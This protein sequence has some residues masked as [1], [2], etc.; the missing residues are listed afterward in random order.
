M[1]PCE[2][3][4]GL[5]TDTHY[6]SIASAVGGVARARPPRDPKSGPR[7]LPARHRVHPT[8]SGDDQMARRLR[9]R[10]ASRW[11]FPMG[12]RIPSAHG[13]PS[14]WGNP[15]PWHTGVV[16]HA[17]ALCRCTGCVSVKL[18]LFR[19]QNAISPCIPNCDAL[20]GG[21]RVLRHC[22]RNRLWES[23]AASSNNI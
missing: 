21:N 18:R 2:A 8:T 10:V 17:P 11:A 14:E 22:G 15:L 12:V 4:F 7:E 6:P 9:H 1:C 20:S 16:V 5:L 13:F 19:R 3:Q 23:G